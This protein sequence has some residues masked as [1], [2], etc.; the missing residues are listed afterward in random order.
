[1]RSTLAIMSLVAF[2]LAA[3]GKPPCA[4][5][6]GKRC[7]SEVVQETNKMPEPASESVKAQ[8]P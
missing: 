8:T 7:R 1:M 5:K 6:K 4:P 3:C 2:G